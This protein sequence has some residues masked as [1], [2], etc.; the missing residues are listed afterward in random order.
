MISSLLALITLG[1]PV[2]RPC[3]NLVHESGALAESDA[4][5]AILWRDGAG[6]VVE[7]RVSY[8]G[9]AASFGWI[10]AIP[11]G[12]QSLE[13]GDE[14]R[15]D[16][17]RA[18]SQP[19]VDTFIVWGEGDEDEGCGSGCRA[20]R[21]KGG[22]DFANGLD[23]GGGL[24]VDVVA[25]GFAGDYAFTVVASDDAA[26]L[27]AWLD[28]NGWSAGG[29]QATLDAY[30]AAGDTEFVLVSLA[31]TVADTPEQ[32]RSLP[33]VVIR[34]S[35]PS[36]RFP[37]AMARHAGPAD[38]R[39][40]VYVIGD[41]RARLISGFRSEDL[42]TL[43]GSGGEEA[44]AVYDAALW[45]LAGDE[46]VFARIYAD[47]WQGEEGAWLT[48]FDTWAAASAHQA[49]SLFQ[50]DDGATAQHLVIEIT[51][52]APS[53]AGVLPLLLAFGGLG[54]LLRRRG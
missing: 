52:D 28:E 27:G 41:A 8:A 12:F 45:E 38:F 44:E 10:I 18:R 54:W 15:F 48:R 53:G 5:E 39:T 35:S 2:A 4:Q 50:D 46:P 7:Y 36:L 14:A 29:T 11:K 37:S 25:E 51:E 23:T 21:L 16:S 32:G 9:D 42:D 34:S 22:G 47:S 31:P 30:V 3:A 43:Y 26:A 6:S 19:I 20:T 1:G 33:P 24:G 49:D 40:T 13:E 17:L